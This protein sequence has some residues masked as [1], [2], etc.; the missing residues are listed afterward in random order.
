MHFRSRPARLSALVLSVLSLVVAPALEAAT[1]PVRQAAASIARAPKVD[2]SVP[3]LYRGS[4][5][6]IDREWIFGEL[7][8]GVRY[9][10]RK[11]HVPPDQVS[12]RVRMDVG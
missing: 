3:W 1:A 12:I 11:N 7:P 2:P 10:V 6:P 8:N 4:N 5:I 9:A